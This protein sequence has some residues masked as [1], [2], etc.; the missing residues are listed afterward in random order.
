MAK[1][2]V[3]GSVLC[4]TPNVVTQPAPQ[5]VGCSGLLCGD[6][7]SSE[8]SAF[9]IGPHGWGIGSPP[10]SITNALPTMYAPPPV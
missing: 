9:A 5:A 10:R 8:I 7:Y 2:D 6:G 3:R 1:V 4:L